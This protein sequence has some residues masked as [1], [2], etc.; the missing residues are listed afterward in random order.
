MKTGIERE[1]PKHIAQGFF[2]MIITGEC[3][4][5]KV[6]AG[7]KLTEAYVSACYD[8]KEEAPA[9]FVA[10]AGADIANP[11]NWVQDPDAGPVYYK[12][13]IGEIGGIE[14]VRLFGWAIESVAPI[15]VER[16]RQVDEEKWTEKHDDE[17]AP[18]EL[19]KAGACYALHAA[20]N[21]TWGPDEDWPWDFKWWK[22]KDARRDLERAGA[23]IAA[24]IGKLQRKEP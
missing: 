16:E 24:E 2:L 1:M 9:E 12:E 17:H 14:F 19:A 11:D 4:N 8:P 5:T 18:G 20:Y 13:S 23:L 22:P 15:A 3:Y 10:Q 6:V 21:G 7:D